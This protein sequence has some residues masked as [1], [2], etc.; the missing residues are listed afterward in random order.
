[1][2][3]NNSVKNLLKKAGAN[4][5]SE[6]I[7]IKIKKMA[8]DYILLIGR[9]AIKNAEYSGRKT[10]RKIDIQKAPKAEEETLS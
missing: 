9:K 7:V 10:I 8:E 6:E 1:M 5:V 3:S 2:I 4:R